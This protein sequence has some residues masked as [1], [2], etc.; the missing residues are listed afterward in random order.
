MPINAK[1][2]TYGEKEKSHLSILASGFGTVLVEGTGLATWN[3]P[4]HPS[5]AECI[6]L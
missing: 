5:T 4:M 1:V 6:E 2:M 3:T